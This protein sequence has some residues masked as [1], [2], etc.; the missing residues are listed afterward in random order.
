MSEILIMKGTLCPDFHMDKS[1]YREKKCLVSYIQSNLNLDSFK[2][3]L[4]QIYQGEKVLLKGEEI[5][6]LP[7][8]VCISHNHS[9]GKYL[10]QHY[11]NLCV[12]YRKCS[13]KTGQVSLQA[14]F[15]VSMR[16]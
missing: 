16:T 6:K 4:L 9:S 7:L 11:S 12:I 2:P 5:F 1:S 15:H 3:I 14:F 13:V 8:Q 10:A